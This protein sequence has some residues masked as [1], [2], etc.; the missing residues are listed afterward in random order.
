MTER[1]RSANDILM[2]GGAT[3]VSFQKIGDMVRGRIL[4]EPEVRDQTEIGTGAVRTFADG[5]ARKQLVIALQTDLRNPEDPSDTGER[6]LWA[7]WKMIEAIRAAVRSAGAKGLEVGGELAVKYTGDG[8]KG[9]F[10]YPPKLFQALYIPP[11]SGGNAALMNDP[12]MFDGPSTMSAEQGRPDTTN[13][14]GQAQSADPPNWG[15]A[16]PAAQAAS[17]VLAHLREVTDRQRAA[18]SVGT[19]PAHTEAPF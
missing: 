8:V 3:A 16:H 17:S 5:S 9:N 13:H 6:S 14:H 18:G 7:K 12:A 2:G 19:D 1:E 15:A 10:P 4:A 11:P